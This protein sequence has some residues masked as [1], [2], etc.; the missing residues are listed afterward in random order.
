MLLFPEELAP[1]ATG[2]WRVCGTTSI[3]GGDPRKSG[4][5]IVESATD[6]RSAGTTRA[7]IRWVQGG[8][9]RILRGYHRLDENAVHHWRG[10]G[11]ALPL[12]AS[13]RIDV[14]ADGEFA[15]VRSAPTL[16]TGTTV[17]V[18]AR[19]TVAVDGLRD[20]AEREATDLGISRSEL[21]AFRWRVA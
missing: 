12:H 1:T 2:T 18:L 4:L 20:R 5:E 14:D 7:D 16:R 8:R 10:L 9:T 19:G 17:W 21:A 3:F 13:G 6:G 15:L 11:W